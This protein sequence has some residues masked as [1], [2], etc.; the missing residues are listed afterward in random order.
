[1]LSSAISKLAPPG[2]KLGLVLLP[3]FM[4]NELSAQ[5]PSR[6]NFISGGAGYLNMRPRRM[7]ATIC[8]LFPD[9]ACKR[10]IHIGA[11]HID[12]ALF[13]RHAETSTI[14]GQVLAAPGRCKQRLVFSEQIA[15]SGKTVASE[16][17]PHPSPLKWCK[18]SPS[19]G[20]L[21]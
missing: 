11:L 7:S 10:A 8:F 17:L 15:R 9:R 14:A 20:C 1:M 18:Q 3:K 5:H 19:R 21:N 2:R 6:W 16:R 13:T 4:R 12:L